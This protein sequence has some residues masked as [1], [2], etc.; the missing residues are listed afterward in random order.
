MNLR[1]VGALAALL[2]TGAAAALAQTVASEPPRL[3]FERLEID[4]SGLQPRVCLRFSAPLATEGVRYLD[5]LAIRPA[6][7]PALSIDDRRLCMTGF[8]YGRDYEV[9]LRTGLP[10]RGEARI[11]GSERVNITLTARPPVVTITG[12]GRVLARAASTGLPITTVNVAEVAMQ[13]F[14]VGERGWAAIRQEFLQNE[15]RA[16]PYQI[17]RLGEETGELVWSGTLAIDNQP[18][19]EV[20]TAFPLSEVIRDKK[21]GVYWIV[22]SDASRAGSDEESR[23]RRSYAAQWVVSTDLALS[24]LKG[25]DGLSVF[26]RGFADARPKAGVELMLIARNNE[27]LGRARTDASG[28]ATFAPGLMRGGASASPIAVMAFGAGEDFAVIDL[29]RPAFDLSDRGV[30]GRSPPGPVDVYAWTERGIYRPGETAEFTA[31]LRSQ[32]GG[33]IASLPAQLVLRRPNGTEARRFALSAD[34]SGALRQSIPLSP[35]SARG[36][37]SAEILLDPTAAPIGRTRFEVEDFVPQ[38]L[39]VE[40][41][42]RATAF[43]SGEAAVVDV[44]SRFLY[45]APAADLATEAE[46]TIE[47]DAEPWARHRGYVF[48]D[49]LEKAD[50]PAF[51]LAI[52]NTDKDGKAAAKGEVPDISTLTRPLRAQV[53]VAVFEPGGRST[54][55]T[56]TIKLKGPA[57]R[58]GLKPLFADGRVAWDSTARFEVIAVDAEGERIAARD[59]EYELVREEVLWNWLRQNNAWRYE[60]VVRERVVARG[61]LAIDADRPTEL[62]ADVAWGRYRMVLRRAGQPRVEASY[63]L[64]AGWGGGDL[65][66]TPD[67]LELVADKPAYRVGESARLK[68]DST[69][70]GEA[71]VLVA[72]DRVHSA[73]HVSVPAGGAT[74]EIP[75][76][77]EWGP[78]AY[79]LVSLVRPLEPASA[80][81]APVRAV[82]VAWLG[83]DNA[84]RKLALALDAPNL[85]RPRG[86]VDVALRV[87]GAGGAEA[88][89]V[90]AAVDEGILQLTRYRTPD[91]FEHVFGKRRLGL[92]LRDDYGRLIDGRAG[93]RGAIRAGG[94]SGLGGKGLDVVPVKI[95][96][97]FHGPIALDA[98]GRANV[99]LDI[100]DFVGE[101]RLMA[102]AWSADK[103]GAG[104]GK[105]TIRDPLV[106]DATFPRFL[107]PGDESRLSLWLHNVE[108]QAGSYRV[109]WQT[110]GPV[111]ITAG[112]AQSVDLA[113]DA[114]QLL[115]WPI[116]AGELGITTFKLSVEGPGGLAFT[117]DWQMQVRPAQAPTTQARIERIVPG[118]SLRLDPR[119]LA[120]YV[121]GSVQGSVELA[122]WRGFDVPALLRALDR[123]PFGCLEQT[124]SRA[125]PLVYFNDAA[126]LI[127]MRGDRDVPARVQDA[128]WR[129]LDMQR[130]DGGFGL[131]GPLD[132]WATPWL[133]SYT[134]DFLLSARRAGLT[135]PDEALRRSVGWLRVLAAGMDDQ[136]SARAYALYILAREGRADLGTLRYVH[137]VRGRQMQNPLVLAQLGAALQM[138]GDNARADATFGRAMQAMDRVLQSGNRRTSFDYYGTNLRDLAGVV[139]AAATADRGPT[140]EQLF[141]HFGEQLRLPQLDQTTTQE[142]SWMLIATNA[143]ARRARPIDVVING[144]RV[145]DRS[146][147]VRDLDA[148]LIAGGLELVNRGERE[149]WATATISGVAKSPLP[150][151]N[152]RLTVERKFYTLAGETADLANV[153]R[154]DRLVVALEIGGFNDADKRLGSDVAIMDLLP[155]GLEI[156]AIVRREDDSGNTRF[157]FLGTVTQLATREARDD[158]FVAAVRVKD[159]DEPEVRTAY[160]VRA[161]T[162]GRYVL[163]GTVV[164]DMYRPELFARGAPGR[165]DI[166][167]R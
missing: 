64:Y 4:Q 141:R 36:L 76:A 157:K 110:S 120:Q 68:I 135:V 97:L 47:F 146:R 24:V 102:V 10:G 150:A 34:A 151:A 121:P 147:H 37:W 33:A 61:Q 35:S 162:P 6:V 128:I 125:F 158:R 137:D 80:T 16:H 13:V 114:R 106:A 164:E 98:Q 112:T 81:R 129:V 15:R 166:A 5:F 77:S 39:K 67:R 149:V 78:G 139:A 41:T 116:V 50:F 44:V 74:I 92:E 103:L 17:E 160:L 25:A 130:A 26:V 55:D 71:L 7:Q 89:V 20:V 27:E 161:I 107:A 32:T 84:T 1:H 88:R 63:R 87:E 59:V 152:R 72:T 53:R 19:R 118:G 9:E 138:A 56:T 3:A 58:V 95:V 2:V 51:P 12:G 90:L 18:N 122:S 48:G 93:T 60:E 134:I 52:E 30:E 42:P 104:E 8:A 38:K 49:V 57:V 101:L 91:P 148:R 132:E 155:A 165:V 126:S 45:G 159:L 115:S 105:I 136:D 131:W 94:D 133:Q 124:T 144:E 54:A 140:I 46:A 86:P 69:Y 31:L 167:E 23:W 127:G 62:G 22:A 28:R 96:S 111:A 70:A 108:G 143:L 85:A 11:S 14:R 113:R 73:R 82:G 123:Y 29:E 142:Q 154:N 21:P 40:L 119:E 83:I 163:P 43:A 117:R 109:S 145:A 65:D 66:R 99:R 153:K 156:E 75:A 79:A 100:P